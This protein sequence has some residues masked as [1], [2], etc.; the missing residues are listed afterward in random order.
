MVSPVVWGVAAQTYVIAV[1]I[2]VVAK[3]EVTHL[4]DTI[5]S[6]RR[7]GK[8]I[9]EHHAAAGMARHPHRQ[10]SRHHRARAHDREAGRSRRPRGLDGSAPRPRAGGHPSSATATAHLSWLPSRARRCRTGRR[11][12]RCRGPARPRRSAVPFACSP[13]GVRHSPSLPSCWR[14][15]WRVAPTVPSRRCVRLRHR[16]VP[17]SARQRP[18]TAPTGGT[19]AKRSSCSPSRMTGSPSRA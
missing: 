10:V 16:P 9:E 18:A 12:S 2:P 4:I 15:W 19:R 13:P 17:A 3:D 14:C 5:L 1:T 11:S 7:I 6:D 8:V